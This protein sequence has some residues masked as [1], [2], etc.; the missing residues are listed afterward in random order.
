MTIPDFER[1]RYRH[2]VDEATILET[3]TNRR[4]FYASTGFAHGDVEQHL[5]VRLTT[6]STVMSPDVV[7][8]PPQ[9]SD[10]SGRPG[11]ALF[12]AYLAEA[13][14]RP[15]IAPNA[16]GVDY[17]AFRAIPH[18]ATYRMT[19]DQ[20]EALLGGSFA[21]VGAAIMRA[22]RS[23]AEYWGFVDNPQMII[24]S[25]MGAALTAGILTEAAQLDVPLS[26]VVLSETVNGMA[27]PLSTL[28]PQFIATKD[29][30][31]YLDKNPLPLQAAGE[32][33]AFWL[34]R[35]FEAR[36]ANLVYARALALGRIADDLSML[37]YL[38]GTPVYLTRGGASELCPPRINAEL[39]RLFAPVT[40]VASD[41]IDH[42]DHPFTL[43]VQSVVDEV[44]TLDELRNDTRP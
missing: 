37:E 20:R 7:V 12:D 25:S 41:D 2:D 22:V 44:R 6:P 33:R 39:E 38:E 18:D 16:P 40:C 5:A 35:V 43:T 21:R 31:G 32:S 4:T 11:N 9:W 24:G 28:I 15:V 17:P 34:W 26:G 13:I 3:I 1:F 29:S 36:Q 14:G 42:A 30:V 8:R 19:P 10:D 23:S 27:R